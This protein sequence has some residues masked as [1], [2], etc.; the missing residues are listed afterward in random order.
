M[1]NIPA[2]VVALQSDK[3]DVILVD[4]P[5]AEGIVAANADLCIAPMEGTGNFNSSKEETAVAI[6]VSK[7]KQEL[8]NVLNEAIGQIPSEEL[9][10]MIEDSC[11]YQPLEET[12]EDVSTLSFFEMVNLLVHKYG[13]IFVKGAGIALLL[14]L[15]G[16]AFGTLIGCVTGAAAAFEVD[17]D[18]PYPKRILIRVIHAMIAFYV[19]LFRG[20]PMMVQAMVFY[21]G[22]AQLF[23][24]A[25]KGRARTCGS[26]G[27]IF[28]LRL[29]I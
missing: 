12:E 24:C 27:W 2:M 15:F 19:W 22:A 1:E 29:G 21:Y 7:G 9:D 25:I 18:A 5:T 11:Q 28:Y 23:W 17:E 13:L 6:A 20:T 10:K 4:R 16:T 14:A 26:G 3:V 8:L